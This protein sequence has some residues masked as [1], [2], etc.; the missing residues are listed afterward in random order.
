MSKSVI[1]KEIIGG[2][3]YFVYLPII[4]EIKDVVG[5]PVKFKKMV[6]IPDNDN[7]PP[8]N[9]LVGYSINGVPIRFFAFQYDNEDSFLNSLDS[10]FQSTVRDYLR[11]GGS[12][13]IGEITGRKWEVSFKLIMETLVTA[14]SRKPYRNLLDRVEI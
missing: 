8:V 12:R 9:D 2:K 3:E 14:E 7:K 5:H 1:Y 10:S 6:L 4:D 11:L 13:P